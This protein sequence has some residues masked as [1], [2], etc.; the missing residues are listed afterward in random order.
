AAPWSRAGSACPGRR[1]GTPPCGSGKGRSPEESSRCAPGRNDPVSERP[2]YRPEAF[3]QRERRS[4]VAEG[5]AG[6]GLLEAVAGA[7]LDLVA[8]VPQARVEAA[9]VERAQKPE[10]LGVVV[11]A[12]LVQQRVE[13]GGRPDDIAARRG[14]VR[15]A[16]PAERLPGARHARIVGRRRAPAIVALQ[17]V[18]DAAA[19]AAVRL[20]L[21]RHHQLGDGDSGLGREHGEELGP[22]N[23]PAQ[24]VTRSE[25]PVRRPRRIFRVVQGQGPD[26]DASVIIGAARSCHARASY[27]RLAAVLDTAWV[28]DHLDLLERALRDR[29]AQ[30]SLD[31]FNSLDEARRKVLREVETLKARRNKASEQIA[32]L[33][34]DKKDAAALI[35]E[36]RGLGDRIKELDAKVAAI[37]ASL[38]EWL[39][40]VP[41]VPHE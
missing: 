20:V 1:R 29:G 24:G 33:K 18:D 19:A 22:E 4:A 41:N 39:L 27:I 28:R 9:G 10:R 26:A 16:D 30:V 13:E 36:M 23:A 11:V 6:R 21:V 34:K 37:D 17:A 31:E 2:D 8:Q 12:E 32:A 25:Q 7:G 5:T 38:E 3:E 14:A 35:D 15:H 40:A